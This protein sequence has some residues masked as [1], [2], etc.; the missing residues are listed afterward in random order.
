MGFYFFALCL[1]LFYESFHHFGMFAGMDGEHADIEV[2]HSFFS[3]SFILV[4][5]VY[6][7]EN[8]LWC[9]REAIG[10][11]AFNPESRSMVI[12]IISD[13]HIVISKVILWTLKFL[14]PTNV[15]KPFGNILLDF[16]G[17]YFINSRPWWRISHEELL[18]GVIDVFVWFAEWFLPFP[19]K[20]S[21]L[22][23]C[24]KKLFWR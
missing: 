2:G 23:T 14:F 24:L 8:L 13:V 20:I 5:W 11:I 18:I 10:I 21:E 4:L 7:F 12:L 19:A 17:S 15:Q 9:Q 6:V 22:I 16:L 3:N 1:R